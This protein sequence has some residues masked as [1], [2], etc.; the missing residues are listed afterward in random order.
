MCSK[1]GQIAFMKAIALELGPCNIRANAICLGKVDTAI[2]QT[3]EARDIDNLGK[4]V[5]FPEGKIPLT[6]DR[7][8]TPEDV[9]QL[10]LFLASDAS[11]FISGT[12]VWVDGA[13]SLVKA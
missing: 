3:I 6:N 13:E 2:N 9:A 7:A 12:E 5:E 11:R 1:A 10:A 4:D 8:G